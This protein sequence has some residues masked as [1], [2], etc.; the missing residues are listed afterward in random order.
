MAAQIE[1]RQLDRLDR[2]TRW[3]RTQYSDL[4]E[5]YDQRFV[6]ITNE[7][8]IEDDVDVNELKRKLAERG[9]NLSDVL[10]EFIRDKR[11]QQI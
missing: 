6:A 8:V 3:L 1:Q 5:N 4:L 9:M 2:D 7:R 10:V 11:D